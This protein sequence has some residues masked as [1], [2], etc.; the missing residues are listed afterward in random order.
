[1][2]LIAKGITTSVLTD[3]SLEVPGG[4]IGTLRGPSGAG[5][6]LLLRAIADLDPHEGEVWFDGVAQSET[7]GPQ[8]RRQVRLV[9][10]EA[11]WWDDCVGPHFRSLDE[12]RAMAGLLDLPKD[13]MTWQVA[14]LS[15][16]EKQ[17]LGFLRAVEDRPAVLLLDEPTAALD[18]ETGQNVETMIR[19][20]RD[21]GAAILLVTH[22]DAQANRLAD[23][24]YAMETGRLKAAV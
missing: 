3:C 18:A 8:W 7:S 11:A 2:R 22:S 5:K 24:R 10:A 21:D 20:L 15:T 13:C 12:A 17:R 6:S 23:R 1:M 19:S 16:G 14:R 4:E 9:P